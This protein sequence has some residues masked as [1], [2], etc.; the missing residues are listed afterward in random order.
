[1]DIPRTNRRNAAAAPEMTI[2]RFPFATA[3][4]HEKAAWLRTFQMPA[5]AQIIAFDILPDGPCL[6][7][8]CDT[9]APAENRYIATPS[10]GQKLPAHFNPETDKRVRHIA[11]KQFTAASKP[12]S[13]NIIHV[14]EVPA[15]FAIMPG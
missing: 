5:G 1:M 7:A 14:F 2:L 3:N 4:K 8:L 13:V 15:M 9:T 6:Y 12:G 11:T 10:T